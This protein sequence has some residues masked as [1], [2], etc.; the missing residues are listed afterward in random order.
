MSLTEA[1]MEPP[2]PE[3]EFYQVIQSM[4][5][6][7]AYSSGLGILGSTFTLGKFGIDSLLAC[8]FL[9]FF[10]LSSYLISHHMMAYCM[11][12][13]SKE[14][15]F[16]EYLED[17]LGKCLAVTYDVLLTVHNLILLAYVQFF[18]AHFMVETAH[19]EGN[20]DKAYYFLAV[21]N[22][23]L[24]YVSL[25]GDF[26][27]NKWFCIGLLVTWTYVFLGRLVETSYHCSPEEYWEE[28]PGLSNQ[29][30]GSW[31][32][33]LL[34]L[35]IYF[36]SAFQA[37]P[38]VYKEVRN[39]IRMNKV[40]NLSAFVTLAVYLS[41][42]FFYTFD[43][44][45]FT[46]EDLGNGMNSTVSL[47]ENVSCKENFEYEVVSDY[48]HVLAGACAVVINVIPARFALAQLLSG[49]DAD[50]MKKLSN[51]DRFLSALLIFVSI[52]MA[53]CMFNPL[54]WRIII[55]LGVVLSSVLGIFVPM[56]ATLWTEEY[57]KIIGIKVASEQHNTR[58]LLDVSDTGKKVF[59]YF[60]LCWTGTLLILG[61]TS[62]VFI[63]FDI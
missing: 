47:V 3:K 58:P 43:P 38:F 28:F 26:K 42:Y 59:L 55:A 14:F 8:F 49:N 40:I 52:I 16:A 9:M 39:E 12:E 1:L 13:S 24:I 7:V 46:L 61:V 62:G 50:T 54:F 30:F 41:V 23:P 57:S 18:M 34:G 15:N 33:K 31:V 19:T 10:V 27:K 51:S 45:S 11:R 36:A 37:V 21:V 22:I 35:Q 25:L 56:I 20:G 17:R 6:M 53:L 32:I 2:K 4:F 60:Y 63:L 5:F 29:G 48:G 44:K